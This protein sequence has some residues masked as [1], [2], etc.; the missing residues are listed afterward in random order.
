MIEPSAPSARTNLS[1]GPV[2]GR[3]T[4]KVA[5]IT[6]AGA[7]QG[8]EVALLFA[9]AGAV[10]VG[11]DIDHASVEETR[12]LAE[13]RGLA[14]DI[15]V[16]DAADRI[17]MESWV[18]VA[19]ARYGGVDVLYNNGGSARFAPFAELTLEDWHYTLRFELDIVFLP[20]QAAWPHMIKGGGGSIINIASIAGMRGSEVVQGA[21][22]AAHATGKSGVI[23]LTRQMAAEG[24]P[25]G[26][27]VNAISPGPIIT[28]ASL[29]LMEQSPRFR[30][31]FEGL[32]ILGRVGRPADVAYAGLF[33]AS[34]E[35]SFV[36]GVNFPVDGGATARVGVSL[37]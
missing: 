33:L 15:S 30:A 19:A 34:D 16:Q 5:L 9:K 13:Q 1:D 2:E 4:G 24:A 10:V 32:P 36:T 6:G 37:S 28:Q 12:S 35:S 25:H 31:M 23:G 20:S 21:G 27:R 18:G 17:Q 26:I 29:Q 3:L 8:R 14:L 11:C 22:Q 7:G